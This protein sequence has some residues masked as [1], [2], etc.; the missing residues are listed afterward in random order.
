MK[1]AYV[2]C[3]SVSL[4]KKFISKEMKEMTLLLSIIPNLLINARI[5]VLSQNK[6]CDK[7]F[8]H[9]NT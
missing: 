9:E 6:T 1:L 3:R 2:R 8:R 7:K 4:M 5:V